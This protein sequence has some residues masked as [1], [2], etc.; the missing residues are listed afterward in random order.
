[1]SSVVTFKPVTERFILNESTIREIR[2][3]T[4]K[5]GFNGLGEVV[6][7][8]TYSRDNET[9][10]D[11]V[12][13][14]IQGIMSI[15]QEHFAR[16]TLLWDETEWQVRAHDMAISMFKM[17]W[18][19]PGRGLWICGTE[20]VYNRGGMALANCGA[21]DTK[22][23]L[24]L[25][26][27]WTMDALTLGVGVGFSTTWKGE[28]T[29]PDKKDYKMMTIEDSREGWCDSLSQLMCS[30]IYSKRFGKNKFPKFDY[31][32]LRPK[33]DP[34]KG[35][36]GI[37]SGCE[38]LIKLHN[39]VEYYLDNFCQGYITVNDI[40][41]KY[42]H[43]R[44][45]ADIFNSIGV[46]IVS[47]NV[48]RSAE[49]CL[50][51]AKDDTF[52]NLKNYTLNPE[53]QGHG[54]MSNNSVIMT[55]EDDCD[56]F[57]YI[58]EMARRIIDN[59][60]PGMVNAVN[61]GKY[62]RS[63]KHKTDRGTLVNPCSEIC[64]ESY[65][66]CILAETFPTR[67]SN[68]QVFQKALQHAT[69]YA[70]SVNLLATHSYDTNAIVS[71]N[72]RIGVSI[73]GIAQWVS[74]ECD[75]GWGEMN[76]TRLTQ[77]LRQSYPIVVG[78]N[79]ILAEQAGIPPSIR[80]TTVKPSGSISLLA[81]CTPGVHYPT[82]RRAI[83]RMRIGKDSPLVPALIKSGLPH[84]LDIHCANTE[85]FEFVVDHGKV[86]PVAEVTPW[87]QLSL[88]ALLQRYWSDNLVSATVTFDKVRDRDD[89]EKMLAI[90]IPL[91]KSISMLPTSDNGY[92]QA[93]YEAI[94]EE[95]YEQRLSAYT[96]P[97]F[98]KVQ[99]NVPDGEMYCTNDTCGL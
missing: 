37:A 33:G 4:P 57:T 86:R 77:I 89:I 45:V 22:D 16:N 43:T 82:S 32:L 98:G 54:W 44:L 31:S 46:C 56:D 9:W 84:E 36:G 13:R 8:R 62:A 11:V 72:R 12:I 97:N 24:V 23:D 35:F 1:M 53:R 3:M 2:D 83:R 29:Q 18:L 20:Y 65:E 25:S 15:R 87:E 5:F 19:P 70:S 27:R 48:R 94:T 67:C 64:L 50:G 41:K 14:V 39:D 28:A 75:K 26:A 81:G 73:S 92:V 58:P 51:S 80:C 40:N 85:I 90:F 38:P 68:Y 49:L 88:V 6:F 59:G 30:Y 63:G 78:E 71:R 42:D 55:H 76:Y 47:G 74:G 69:F 7:R 91:L 60:E 93:P 66:L 21:T 34:I 96:L 61:M 52:M 99:G 95:E 10:H 17:E 79:K